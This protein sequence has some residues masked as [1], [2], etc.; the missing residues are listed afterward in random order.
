RALKKYE[1]VYFIPL[2]SDLVRSCE[3]PAESAKCEREDH[4]FL[5]QDPVGRAVTKNGFCDLKAQRLGA[6]F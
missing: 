5:S 2:F 6:R 3:T 4:S 1:K